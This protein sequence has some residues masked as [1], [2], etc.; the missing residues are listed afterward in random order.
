MLYDLAE[1]LNSPSYRRIDFACAECRARGVGSEQ[2]KQALYR[3]AVHLPSSAILAVIFGA[4]C[5]SLAVEQILK[6]LSAD[7]FKNV[8]TYWST[9]HSARYAVHYIRADAN[10]IRFFYEHRD[11][12]VAGAKGH[13]MRSNDRLTYIPSKKTEM[14][15]MSRRAKP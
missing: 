3:D 4:D 7:A 2:C 12:I 11:S 10:Y 14:Y 9:L 1:L 15:D 8:V 6:I 5:P 13:Y